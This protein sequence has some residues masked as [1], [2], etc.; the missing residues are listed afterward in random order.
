MRAAVLAGL[1]LLMS[2][3]PAA[4]AGGIVV[5]G[6]EFEAYGYN[7]LG[8]IPIGTEWCSGASG[9]YAAG[10]LDLPGEWIRLK[11]SFPAAACYASDIAYQSSYG[12]TVRLTVRMGDA[13]GPGQHIER[14]HLLTEG[15]GFG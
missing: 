2:A 1:V 6:E 7:D 13:P 11:V 10:G 4:G 3:A 14:E 5:E 15:W 8:G 9:F 12:D